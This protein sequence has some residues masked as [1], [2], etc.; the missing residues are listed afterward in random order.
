M[1]T[2]LSLLFI[3]SIGLNVAFLT[4][5]A[6]DAFYGKPCK[7]SKPSQPIQVGDDGREAFAAIASDLGLPTSGRDTETLKTDIHYAISVKPPVPRLFDNELFEKMAKDLNSSEENAMREYQ[8][9]IRDLQGK[10]IIVITPK[11]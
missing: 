8:R 1:K 3:A 11:D 10:R 6:H 7:Y 4:G 9:F 2:L 5:C